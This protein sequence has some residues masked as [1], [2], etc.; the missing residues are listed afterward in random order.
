MNVNMLCAII[1][2]VIKPFIYFIALQIFL[3]RA[4]LSRPLIVGM[5]RMV[6]THKDQLG[7]Q[8][9]AYFHVSYYE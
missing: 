1:L 9:L 5:Y 7:S 3:C 6:G 4:T 8:N 2:R